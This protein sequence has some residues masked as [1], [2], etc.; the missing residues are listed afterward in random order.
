MLEWT[1]E[2]RMYR[3]KLVLDIIVVSIECGLVNKVVNVAEN[4]KC[5]YEIVFESPVACDLKHVRKLQ[6]Q[7]VEEIDNSASTTQHDEL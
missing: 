5:L 2:T 6:E 1:K 4:G 7:Q 3:Q